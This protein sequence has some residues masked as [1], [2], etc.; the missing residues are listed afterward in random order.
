MM[1][2]CRCPNEGCDF[3]NGGGAC[4]SAMGRE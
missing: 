1:V 2:L 3:G 4:V